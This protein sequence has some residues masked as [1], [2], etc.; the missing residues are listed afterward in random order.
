MLLYTYTFDNIYLSN[1]YS[2]Y[3]ASDHK[4]EVRSKSADRHIE[5]TENVTRK[6]RVFTIIRTINITQTTNFTEVAETLL[7]NVDNTLKTTENIS[8]RISE[9]PPKEGIYCYKI[10]ENSLR[11]I[12][13]VHPKPDRSIFFHETSC[14]SFVNGKIWLNPRQACAIESAA[15]MNP[16]MDVYVLFSSPGVLKF[17]GDESDNII[18][19]LLSYR[20]VHLL[21]LDYEKYTRN[22]P[23]AE[24]YRSGLI[25]KNVDFAVAHASDMLR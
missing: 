3:N 24:L 21:H 14:N 15:K 20:N 25:E 2:T 6:L 7:S 22:T 8:D 23:I 17:E 9:L 16:H 13:E 12:S 1:N 4:N 10:K 18:Q 5:E 11:D 19:S